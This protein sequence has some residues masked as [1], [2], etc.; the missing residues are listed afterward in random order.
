[1]AG[2]GRRR[3]DEVAPKRADRW[4]PLT[5]RAGRAGLFVVE[6]NHPMLLFDGSLVTSADT[7]TIDVDEAQL[8][9]LW[10]S[11]GDRYDAFAQVLRKTV[12]VTVMHRGGQ[13]QRLRETVQLRQFTFQ[14]LTMLAQHAGFQVR[15]TQRLRRPA[16]SGCGGTT[17]ARC[18]APGLLMRASSA[19]RRG[20]IC[21]CVCAIGVAC[22]Q[23]ME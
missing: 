5:S 3:S 7:W 16:A 2:C 23:V 13:Q 10:G 6:M 21:M 20:R 18:G 17:D 8:E 1:M 19:L 9:V 22:W 14:E 12:D 15:I 11:E 4:R